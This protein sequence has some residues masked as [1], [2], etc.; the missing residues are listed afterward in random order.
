MVAVCKYPGEVIE[1]I[2]GV[3]RLLFT[4]PLVKLILGVLAQP[5]KM[6]QSRKIP[7]GTA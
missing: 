4:I 7:R 5:L 1:L 6:I 2:T 3:F